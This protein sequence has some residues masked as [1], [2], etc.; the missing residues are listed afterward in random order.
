ML[1]K[2]ETNKKVREIKDM[3]W[4]ENKEQM[5]SNHIITLN[6]NKLNIPKKGRDRVSYKHIKIQLQNRLCAK[7]TLTFKYIKMFEV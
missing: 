3:R 7:N 2:K 5:E 6:T 4:T 1:N